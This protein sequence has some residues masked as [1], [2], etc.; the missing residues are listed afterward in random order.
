MELSMALVQMKGL[1]C[2]ID[3]ILSVTTYDEHADL[4]GLH[5]DRKDS[6]QLFQLREMQN[7][8]RRLADI[9]G[10]IEYLFRPVLETSTLHRDENGEYRTGK[11]Y[12]YRSGS[13]IEALLQEDPHEALCWVQTKVEHDGEDYYLMGYEDISMEGLSVRV[14]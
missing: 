5:A 12:C 11:G 1:K 7:I 14:R 3:D 9:G 13:L 8:M 6:E 2:R 4:R 10:S